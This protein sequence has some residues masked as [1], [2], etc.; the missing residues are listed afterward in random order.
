[1]ER[2]PF[3][4][5]KGRRRMTLENVFIIKIGNGFFSGYDDNKVTFVLDNQPGA[6]SLAKRYDSLNKAKEDATIFNG[7]IVRIEKGENHANNRNWRY[8]EFV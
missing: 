5:K 3:I 6:M 2:T 7:K 1:M 4:M 8:S